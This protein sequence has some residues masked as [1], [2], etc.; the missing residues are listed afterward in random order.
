MERSASLGNKQSPSF[1]LD[2]FSVHVKHLRSLVHRC[3]S[4]SLSHLCLPLFSPSPDA[5]LL[6][7]LEEGSPPRPPD[8]FIRHTSQK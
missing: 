1:S 2:I 5:A 3:A 6:V 8:P 4:W 7:L